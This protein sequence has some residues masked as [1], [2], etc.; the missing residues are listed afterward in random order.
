MTIEG[1]RQFHDARPFRPFVMCM[2]NGRCLRVE[3][4]E[5]LAS[6]PTGRVAILFGEGDAFE[7]IDL[8][9]VMSISVEDGKNKGRRSNGKK[10]K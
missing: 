8:L 3:H 7:M 5:F 6:S 4:P 2:T 10:P 1:L 9:H